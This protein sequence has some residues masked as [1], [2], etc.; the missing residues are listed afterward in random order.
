MLVFAIGD[1]RSQSFVQFT[2]PDVQVNNV[3]LPRGVVARSRTT[4][5]A[6]LSTST[7]TETTLASVTWTPVTGRRYK[8]TAFGQLNAGLA[9]ALNV[10][11]I[12]S[13]S[14]P[15]V[16][17]QGQALMAVVGGPGQ[18]TITAYAEW[19]TGDSGLPA[20]SLSITLVGITTVN[21]GTASSVTTNPLYLTI[22]D[23]G[24]A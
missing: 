5:G 3:S 11:R 15:T 6:T 23:I 24:A 16:L 22:E 12:K 19:A 21:A 17:A 2:A 9:N 18:T 8:F 1:V 14:G 4:A 10:L 20:T 7:S 13:N